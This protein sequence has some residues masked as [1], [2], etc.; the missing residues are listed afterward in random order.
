[1]ARP[2]APKTLSEHEV[3]DLKDKLAHMRH[4]VN[5]QLSLIVA[6][7]EMIRFKP[8]LRDKMLDNL[9]RQPLQI[10]EEIARFST[11]FE[12]ALGLVDDSGE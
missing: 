9:A 10:T 11:E 5:N 7:M 12:T 3:K 1:M 4:E 2:I 8:E 6:A